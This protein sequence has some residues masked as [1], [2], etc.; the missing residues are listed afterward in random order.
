[1]AAPLV[2][3]VVPA[4]EPGPRLREALDSVLGQSVAEV[5]VV[6][7]DDGSTED[8]SWV[9]DVDPRVRLL[10]QPNRGVSVARNVGVRAA[11]GGLVAF[12]DQDDTWAGDKL[13]RQLEGWR[14]RPDASFHCT[15]FDWVL[16]T[17]DLPSDPVDPTLPWLLST[18]HVCLSSLLLPVEHYWAVGGHDPTL[19]MMQDFDLFLRL[20]VVLG[21]AH[22][23]PGHLVR[24]AVHDENASRD[25]AAAARERMRILADHEALALRR[26]DAE[27]VRAV[28]EG[29]RRTGE[30]YAH[31]AVDAA[32]R[33]LH[34]RHLGAGLRHGSRAVAFSPRVTGLALGRATIRR[35]TGGR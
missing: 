9:G 1:M 2:S 27:A 21:P 14:E 20:L 10:R 12:L 6:V 11:R 30:L 31:Q 13:E 18:G 34:G 15:A 22:Q 26:G 16:P 29:R 3:V 17:G 35:F 19:R 8:L 25:Y 33:E 5:D 28:A 4:F 23:H 32:R 24:Y 7:V